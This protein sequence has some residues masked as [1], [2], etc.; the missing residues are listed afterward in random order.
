LASFDWNDLKYFLEVAR[1]GTLSGAARVLS[2]DHAT[3]SRR[4]TALE[5]ALGRSLF[6]R[7]TNGYALTPAGED[8]LVQAEQ[9]EI[10]ALRTSAGS[11]VASA[12]GGVV[13]IVT[14]D[15][16]GNFFLSERLPAFAETHP[17]LSVQLVPIQQIQAQTQRD[18]DIGVTLTAGGPRFIAERLGDY[19]LGLYASA[20]YLSKHGTPSTREC[21]RT[22]RF[23][24]YIEDLL[25]SRELDYLDEVSPGLRAQLQFSS[26]LGQVEATIADAGICVLP[27]FIAA[28]YAALT[29]VLPDAISIQ[30]TYWMNVTPEAQRVPRVRALADFVRT[31]C[32]STQ[33]PLSAGAKVLR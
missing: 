18:G 24:G 4:I 32:V 5:Q 21:L 2:A 31:Q 10:L 16:F 19:G 23:I 11:D 20:A 30:R 17:R 27:H 8:L 29:P 1:V 28:R 14:A 22:H 6:Q 25:F 26:L 33:F 9:M 15:G 13:R 7:A 3:V 12:I